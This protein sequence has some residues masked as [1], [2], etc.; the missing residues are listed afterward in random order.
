LPHHDAWRFVVFLAI[1]GCSGCPSSHNGDDTAGD[2]CSAASCDTSCL[3]R[4]WC[5]GGCTDAGSCLCQCTPDAADADDGRADDVADDADR[6]ESWEDGTD[7][8]DGGADCTYR[9]TGETKP[10]AN[11]GMTCRRISIPEAEH[12]LL[13]FAGDGNRVI[14]AGGE[15]RDWLWEFDRGTGCVEP[16]LEGRTPAGAPAWIVGL[17]VEG[18][19]TAFNLTWSPDASTDHC[20]THLHDRE[21]GD[22]RL[23]AENTSPVNGSTSGCR[24]DSIA[25]EYPWVVWRD[26]RYVSAL[27]YPWDVHALNIET[28][29]LLNL[30]NDPAT[31]ERVWGSTVVTDLRGGLAVFEAEWQTGVPLRRYSEVVSVDLRTDERRQITSAIGQQ[32]YPTVTEDWIAWVDERED[33][34]STSFWPCSADIYGFNRGGGTEVPLVTEGDALHGPTLDGEGPW[35][36]YADQRWDPRPLCDEDREQSIVAFH[37]PTMTEIRVTDWPGFEALPKVYDRHD[38]TFGVLLIEEIS[39][40]PAIYRLWDCDLPAM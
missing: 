2:A 33:P 36:A 19:R 23:L 6:T 30:S 27:F 38:G 17:A 32:F 24:M 18:E 3:A 31:G 9:P 35:L 8:D 39:Y 37:L 10:G 26:V 1:L 21:T 15:T 40:A 11:P 4:G 29:E 22:D 34:G 7:R 12:G 16:V 20:E 13:R 14:F 5:S 25:L 28:D